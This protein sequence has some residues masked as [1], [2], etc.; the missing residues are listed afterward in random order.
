M[1]IFKQK[2]KCYFEANLTFNQHPEKVR[3]Y[4]ILEQNGKDNTPN[5]ARFDKHLLSKGNHYVSK[6]L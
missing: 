4:K 3:E 2:K 5:S 6:G 1:E